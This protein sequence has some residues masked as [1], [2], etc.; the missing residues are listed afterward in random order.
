MERGLFLL[1]SWGSFCGVGVGRHRAG[2]EHPAVEAPSGLLDNVLC[3]GGLSP[4][5]I[6]TA[7]VTCAGS[8]PCCI[9]TILF[10][11]LFFH[12]S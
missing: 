6:A 1:I 10:L 2:E 4:G 8:L 12:S 3:V 9:A 11:F 5:I 7:K